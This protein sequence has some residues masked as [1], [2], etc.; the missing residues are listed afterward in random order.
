MGSYGT[1]L[2]KKWRFKK[3][4]SKPLSS[5][6]QLQHNISSLVD[7]DK[8]LSEEFETTSRLIESVVDPEEEADIRAPQLSVKPDHRAHTTATYPLLHIDDALIHY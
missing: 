4:R 5:F 1:S 7:L 8:T 2:Q 3:S 6:F